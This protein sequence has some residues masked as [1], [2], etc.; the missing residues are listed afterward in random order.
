MPGGSAPSPTARNAPPLRA[1][2]TIRT[3]RTGVASPGRAQAERSLPARQPERDRAVAASVPLTGQGPV[4]ALLLGF[5]VAAGSALPG[6]N[7]QVSD[8]RVSTAQLSNADI[9]DL[10]FRLRRLERNFN[11]LKGG[12]PD[13]PSSLATRFQNRLNQM[14]RAIQN[15]TGKVEDLIYRFESLEKER[16]AFEADAEYRLGL[17]EKRAG[18]KG[19]AGRAERA[20]RT[21]T[22]TD[23]ETDAEAKAERQSAGQESGRQKAAAPGSSVLPPGT[24]KEQ[25]RFA[26]GQLRQ[27]RYDEAAAAFREFLESHPD[28]RFAGN[29]YYWLGETHYAQQQYRLAAIRFADGFKKF[30]KHPK[31]PDNLLKLGMSMA[32]LKKNKEACA[33][34]A[35]LKRRYPSAPGYV[36]RKAARERKRL[37]CRA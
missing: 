32:H 19:G 27:A 2:T 10:R 37:G 5:C 26:I 35:E 17:L 8:A 9:D 12:D 33:S 3:G 7:A 1:T 30:P 13:V 31:A 18:I 29:A 15:L 25:Y 24:E 34:W 28:G 23:T 36:K 4:V 16:K 14:E 6:A 22:E 11:A 21:D 20:P